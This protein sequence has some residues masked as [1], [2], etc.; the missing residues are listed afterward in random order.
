VQ[1]QWLQHVVADELAVVLTSDRLDEDGLSPV[2]G[3]AV[4]DDSGAGLPLEREVTHALT[5]EFMIFPG[6]GGTLA[7]GNPA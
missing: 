3:S 2:R 7:S 4:I 6:L 1:S 5:Q